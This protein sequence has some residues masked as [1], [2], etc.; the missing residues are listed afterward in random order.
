MSEKSL[1]PRER[2]EHAILLIRGHKVML[3]ADLAVLYG[4]PTKALNQAV[5]RNSGRFPA[6]FM[7]QLNQEEAEVLRSQ[8]VTSKSGSGGRR[9]LP[10]AFTENGVAMLSSVLNSDRAIQVNIAIMRVFTR[11]RVLLA[12]H[13]DLLRRL[14]EM[15]KKYDEQFQVVFD[16]IRQ[17]MTPPD[18]PPRERIGFDTETRSC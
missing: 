13:A 3:D 14:D 11:L 6:D 5:R 2:I 16:A 10:Y 8:N 4:V 15:E 12:S 18:E 17:L 7:F 1:I 9:Y